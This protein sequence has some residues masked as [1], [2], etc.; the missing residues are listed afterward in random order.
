MNREETIEKLD[1]PNIV[2]HYTDSTTALKYILPNKTL[3]LSFINETNDPA[4]YK[5]WKFHSIYNKK[6]I[7]EELFKA[8]GN[9]DEKT[10]K[11][12][13]FVSFC[14]NK[15]NKDNINKKEKNI[16]LNRDAYYQYLID[17][18]GFS[19]LRMWSQYGEGQNGVC[20]AFNLKELE[21][22]IEAKLKEKNLYWHS[23]NIKYRSLPIIDFSKSHINENKVEEMGAKKYTEKFISENS[24]ELFFTKYNDYKDENEHR[25]AVHD[26]EDEFKFIDI[27]SSLYAIIVGNRFSEADNSLIEDFADEYG[28]SS[29]RINWINGKLT[30]I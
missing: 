21:K 20:L 26:P 27:T 22:E 19:R 8:F 7:T 6:E 15:D 23:N 11:E 1:K 29:H 14:K 25:I 16:L 4:E 30:L 10:L 3:K 12:T 2:Y 9:L 13:R 24:E 18:L 5:T 28:V 17:G